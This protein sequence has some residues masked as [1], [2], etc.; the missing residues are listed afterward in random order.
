MNSFF[1]HLLL[2]TPF[3]K[4]YG[5]LRFIYFTK[6]RIKLKTFDNNNSLENTISY[7]LTAFK[8]I[9]NDFTMNRMMYL[10]HGLL[11]L[12]FIDKNVKIL[13]IGPRTE[14]DLLILNGY[15]FKNVVG[16][17][18]ITYSPNIILGDMHNMPFNA[19]EFDVVI[20]GWT[21]SYS[22]EPNIACDEIYRILSS[23][24]LAIFGFD[25]YNP[26][27]TNSSGEAPVQP[28]RINS[29]SDIK[30]LFEN[31]IS[32]VY[33]EYDAELKN[34]PINEIKKIS[35]LDASVVAIIFKIK[36]QS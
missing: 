36:K 13:V 5:I 23:N 24:G 21:I 19:N 10:I 8:H 14:N 32:S 16:L 4:Y 15:G 34:T 9:G 6:I 7:N 12:E 31:K 30:R 11:S 2:F 1:K 29:I 28:N 22:K 20:C 35:G 3:R 27:N 26:N 18:L 17:D 25:H 33:F